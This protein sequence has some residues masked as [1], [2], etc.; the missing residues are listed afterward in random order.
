MAGAAADCTLGRSRSGGGR[1]HTG[2]RTKSFSGRL[3]D[4]GTRIVGTAFLLAAVVGSGIMGER[5]SG[6]NIAVALL[7][8]TIA[9][10]YFCLC[11]TSSQD[12]WEP[13]KLARRCSIKPTPAWRSCA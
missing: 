5:L 3:L 6:G 9:T 4:A 10:G 13:I 7:A 11:M 12:C 1:R 8:N 2:R